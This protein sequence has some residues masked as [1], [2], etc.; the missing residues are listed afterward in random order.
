MQDA[1]FDIRLSI[2]KIKETNL[3]MHYNVKKILIRY[4]SNGGNRYDSFSYQE[5]TCQENT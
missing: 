5:K 3:E 2:Y 4:I 1:T